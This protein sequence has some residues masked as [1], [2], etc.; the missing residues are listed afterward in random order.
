MLA[1]VPPKR[2]DSKSDFDDL[3]RYITER[4][5]NHEEPSDELDPSD[6]PRHIKILERAGGDLKS[7]EDHLRPTGR[8]AAVDATA[9][10][11]RAA[12]VAR[13]AHSPEHEHGRIGD[14][15]AGNAGEG[16]NEHSHQRSI[17][18]ARHHLQAAAG[19]LGAP[20]QADRDFQERAR[21]RRANL[22]FHA[23]AAA[24]RHGRHARDAGDAE[25]I[26]LKGTSQRLKTAPGVTCEHN[27]LSLGTAAAEMRAVAAQNA[28]VQDP[29]YHVVVSWPS[30]ERPLDDEAFACGTHVLRAVGMA[31]HQYVFA[32][33]RDT[34]NVHMHIAVNRV[35]P[36][37]FAAVYPDRDYYKLARA[38]RQLELRFGWSHDN[39]PL[40]VRERNG[41]SVIEWQHTETDTKGHIPVTAADMERHGDQE[42][43]IS[44]VRGEPR[45]MLVPLLVKPDLSWQELHAQLRRYGVAIREKGQGVAI[46]DLHSETTT[47]VK[48]SDL[49]EDL[50]KGR[51]TKRLG[52]FEPE[53]ASGGASEIDHYDKFRPPKR[54][55]NER[56]SGRQERGELRRDLRARY[57]Q[58]RAQFILRRLDPESVRTR[59]AA[60]RAEVRRRRQ[61]VRTMYPG[62][63]ERKAQYS[64]IAFETLRARERLRDDIQAERQKLLAEHRESYLSFQAWVEQQAALGDAAAISQLRGWAYA[65]QRNA[66]PNLDGAKSSGNRIW[67]D[68]EHDPVAMPVLEGV[69]FRVRRDGAIR[70]AVGLGVVDHGSDI[71]VLGTQ[72]PDSVVLMAL[73]LAVRKFG[74]DFRLS[75]DESFQAQVYQLA[76]QGLNETELV[77][78]VRKRM[79]ESK[80]SR[81]LTYCP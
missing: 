53:A 30:S 50:S 58:Y 67:Q 78:E 60:L 7:A 57:Q 48:A 11:V 75:G 34:K 16:L 12:G 39:G 74:V 44:Y 24:R 45:R 4:D 33:H 25:F 29:V 1:K 23:E 68:G 35:S 13:P 6:R 18:A 14:H 66:E 76:S 73:L 79:E 70:H 21:T 19:H 2:K 8:V 17:A 71:E 15:V 54:N 49:H 56:E 62:K 28:R 80:I 27:C 22:A 3:I 41:A 51:L 47:P 5:D 81:P 32:I 10:R 52:P 77:R 26:Q 59:F 46:F 55:V 64:L 36:L 40:V 42:S 69:P 9:V 20:G 38:M 63:A 72:A 37:T 31:G 43:F 65:G 61:L